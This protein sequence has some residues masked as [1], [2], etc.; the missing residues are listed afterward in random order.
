MC[1]A[2][3]ELLAGTVVVNDMILPNEVAGCLETQDPSGHD[4]TLSTDKCGFIGK[5]E[6]CEW[7]GWKSS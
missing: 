6:L 2:M 1:S 4:C 5:R 7:N 3:W